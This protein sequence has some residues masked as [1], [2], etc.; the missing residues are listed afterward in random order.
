M[1]ALDTINL[2]VNNTSLCE[3]N[4]QYCLVKNDKRPYKVDGSNAKPNNINDFVSL[5][6]LLIADL[7]K[8]DTIGISIQ[9]SNICAID[10]DKC[11][12]SPFD[13][14]T[15]DDR[16]KDII[17][18]FKN[19]AYIEFSFSGKG[20]RVLFRHSVIN[21]YALNYYI[22]NDKT[23]IEFYQPSQSYRYV[24][25][26]G[27]VI[28]NNAI[29]M[30]DDDILFLFLNKYMQRPQIKKQHI[31]IVHHSFEECMKFVKINLFK[32]YIFQ[33]LW[34]KQ[35]PGSNSNESQ[36]DYHLLA[37]LYE[38]IT[39][40]KEQLRQIFEQSNYFKSKDYKHI[41]KW[42]YQNY[43]Y[44]NYVYEQIRRNK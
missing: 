27:K 38:H 41:R 42:T 26:T 5:D 20:L 10:I 9:A 14:N 4:L 1:T 21:N 34:F 22:K 24:T 3:A 44:F 19:I 43:R 15:I 7:S 37:Y 8:F 29:D 12:Q 18:I 23:N 33:D 35:A 28:V 17:N 32:D 31:D 40:D 13:I 39:Q 36:L 25:L 16:G 11:C 30:C 6:N 2:I